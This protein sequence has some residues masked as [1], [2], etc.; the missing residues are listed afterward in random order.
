MLYLSEYLADSSAY[1]Q[2]IFLQAPK[3]IHCFSKRESTID[4]LENKTMGAYEWSFYASGRK[5]HGGYHIPSHYSKLTTA[6]RIAGYEV[7]LPALASMNGS[8]PPN[9]DLV[10]DTALIHS[11]VRSLAAARHIIIATMHSYG[12]Q[13]D[14]DALTGLSVTESIK[15]DTVVSCT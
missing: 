11:C 9:A 14:M 3:T 2:H 15:P 5:I 6:L 4:G 13:V 12:V 8:R 7:Y 1:C 10:T